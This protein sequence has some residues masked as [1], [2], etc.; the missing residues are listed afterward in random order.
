MCAESLAMRLSQFFF[1]ALREHWVSHKVDTAARY[2]CS[3]YIQPW[4]P[5]VEALL[6][7]YLVHVI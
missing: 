2:C 3:L 4:N 1:S 6:Y 5:A 7:T